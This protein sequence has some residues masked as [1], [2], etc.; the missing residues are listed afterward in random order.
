MKTKKERTIQAFYDI[1]DEYESNKGHQAFTNNCKTCSI[2]LFSGVGDCKGCP[3]SNDKG[4]IGCIWMYTF[5]A[6]QIEKSPDNFIKSY[7]RAK[8][9]RHAAEL[10]NRI[11]SRYFSNLGWDHKIFQPLRNLDLKLYKEY[12]DIR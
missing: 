8:Y 5:Q 2:H 9:L 1:A 11:P 10:L 12:H 4:Y 3:H 6:F 7:L